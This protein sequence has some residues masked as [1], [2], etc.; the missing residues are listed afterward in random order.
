MSDE[1]IEKIYYINEEDDNTIT[2]DDF[3]IAKLKKKILTNQ[4]IK[5]KYQTETP[6]YLKTD[7]KLDGEKWRPY[8]DCDKIEVSNF[9]RVRTK[10]KIKVDENTTYNIDDI[11]KQKDID[12]FKG[13]LYLEHYKKIQE[14]CN[15]VFT[16][17]WVYQMVARTWLKSKIID[18]HHISNDGY[19]N[20]VENLMYLEREIHNKVHKK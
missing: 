13:Y 3:T 11:L 12:V 5:S 4:A 8:I 9:G 15:F 1:K 19:D 10:V 7:K 18:V 2:D 14:A 16:D 20:S 6:I 17:N